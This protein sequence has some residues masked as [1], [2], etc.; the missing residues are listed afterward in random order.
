M[1]AVDCEI[2]FHQKCV[3]EAKWRSIAKFNVNHGKFQNVA[4]LGYVCECAT[5]AFVMQ[6]RRKVLV[7]FTLPVD[8]WLVWV[9]DYRF[10]YRNERKSENKGLA[11]L[12]LHFDCWCASRSWS[13]R[14]AAF[15]Q[16]LCECIA[17]TVFNAFNSMRKNR[18]SDSISFVLK[19]SVVLIVVVLRTEWW[20]RSCCGEKHKGNKP[21]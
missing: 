6:T 18:V 21:Q 11:Q 14:R 3:A 16:S 1:V 10:R 4:S 19:S 12:M 17:H 5:T 9:C 15:L 7:R 2:H 8:G 20:K 13:E